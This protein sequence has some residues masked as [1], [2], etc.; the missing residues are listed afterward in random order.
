MV[1]NRIG[2]GS[3]P[4]R[5][6]F[7]SL[8]SEFQYFIVTKNFEY[9]IL[10]CAATGSYQKSKAPLYIIELDPMETCFNTHLSV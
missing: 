7:A 10:C 8:A 6:R 1:K 9:P 2:F 4:D 3:K 5:V